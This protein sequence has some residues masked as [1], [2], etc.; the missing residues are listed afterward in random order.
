M[1]GGLPGTAARFLLA[2]P[3]AVFFSPVDDFHAAVRVLHQRGAAF[4]PVAIVVIGDVP[5]PADFSGVNVAAHHPVRPALASGVGHRLLEPADIFNRVLHLTLEVGG[6]R[7]V[8]QAEAPAHGVDGG[9]EPQ[10]QAVGAVSQKGEPAGVK[11]HAVELVAVQH[12]KAA[13]IGG[14]VKG[15]RRD[16]H[17]AEVEADVFPQHF[18]VVAGDVNDPR[19]LLGHLQYAAGHVVVQR[20]PVPAA[21]QPPAV[22]DVADEIKRVAAHGLQKIQQQR[23]VAAGGAEVGVGDPDRAHRKAPE[24]FRVVFLSA[25]PG[26]RKRGR[27][28]SG[29][30]TSQR[31]RAA[32][33]RGKAA[34]GNGS[35]ENL[36]RGLG[37]VPGVLTTA[38]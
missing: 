18:I 9:V 34:V 26:G 28:V 35:H 12:Q 23:R 15:V 30:G 20:R 36:I 16:L 29:G 3:A 13:A 31:R 10:Q 37:P 33:W 22:D 24:G 17:A 6:Q 14:F 5:E 11:H 32:L 7:P 19:A 1:N 25:R 27:S 38:L 2:S 21:L 4:H 8:R